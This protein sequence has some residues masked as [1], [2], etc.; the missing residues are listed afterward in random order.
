MYRHHVSCPIADEGTAGCR[1]CGC[2]VTCSRAFQTQLEPSKTLKFCRWLGTVLQSFPKELATLRCTPLYW[3]SWQSQCRSCASRCFA[4][5]KQSSIAR[6]R[7]NSV[8][9]NRQALVDLGVSGNKLRCLP[10]SIGRLSSLKKLACNGNQ[11]EELPHSLG[12]LT[13]LAELWL[14]SNKLRNIESFS[15]LQVRP[16]C[17]P[18]HAV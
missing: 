8:M 13:S 3:H 11:L 16:H 2:M 1:G 15:S 18:L 7:N 10:T 9:W 5:I 12:N 4:S 17:M 6:S 14:Q